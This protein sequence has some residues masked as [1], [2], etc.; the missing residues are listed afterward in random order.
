[1]S[2]SEPP[3]RE[4]GPRLALLLDPTSSWLPTPGGPAGSSR[5]A[6]LD[7]PLSSARAPPPPAL[8]RRRCLPSRGIVRGSSGPPSCR[9]CRLMLRGC[10]AGVPSPV[11][12]Q[13]AGTQGFGAGSGLGRSLVCTTARTMSRDVARSAQQPHVRSGGKAL[14]LSWPGRHQGA[15]GPAHHASIA[16]PSC[17]RSPPDPS[18]Q[19]E[20]AWTAHL[21]CAPSAALPCLLRCSIG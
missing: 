3:W 4:R 8:G 9:E 20:R 15:C 14:P 12:A 7:R 17:R 6:P 1:M 11:R 10:R 21:N 13:G 18:A 19:C 5:L 2:S 16:P